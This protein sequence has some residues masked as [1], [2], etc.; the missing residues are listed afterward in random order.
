MNDF[1]ASI[2]VANNDNLTEII[3]KSIIEVFND[4]IVVENNPVQTVKQKAAFKHALAHRFTLNEE[5]DLDTHLPNIVNRFVPRDLMV[6]DA[7]QTVKDKVSNVYPDAVYRFIP[8]PKKVKSIVYKSEDSNVKIEI[9][10][11]IFEGDINE[12]R[13]D[14]EFK[15]DEHGNSIFIFKPHLQIEAK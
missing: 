6:D 13:N 1:L 7:I 8:N 11:E 4:L 15:I 3:Q 12:E 2:E 9:T 5:F 14:F 10:G